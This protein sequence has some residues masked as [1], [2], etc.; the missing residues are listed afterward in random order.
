MKRLIL[1][2]AVF[3]LAAGIEEAN[4][5]PCKNGTTRCENGRSEVC[6]GGRWRRKG[7]CETKK[8][9]ASEKAECKQGETR[10]EA[11]RKRLQ[12]CRKGQWR[13]S[14]RRCLPTACKTKDAKQC[15]G[16]QLY[17]C[18]LTHWAATGVRCQAVAC[19]T[20][21]A[22]KCYSRKVYQCAGPYWTATNTS[23]VPCKANSKRCHDRTIEHCGSNALW[24]KTSP[25][26]RCTPCK[27][28]RC[29]NQRVQECKYG[30]YHRTSLKCGGSC[31]KKGK[32]CMRKKVARK[33]IYYGE[34]KICTGA[35]WTYPNKRCPICKRGS[36]VC[37][38][39]G[40]TSYGRLYACKVGRL[41]VS[42]LCNFCNSTK[43][44]LYTC[45]GTNA[46][47][48]KTGTLY[49]HKCAGG[50]WQNQRKRC[51]P[52][53]CSHQSQTRCAN[54]TIQTCWQKA[55]WL[56]TKTACIACKQGEQRKCIN[57]YRHKCRFGYW[58][59]TRFTCK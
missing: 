27:A 2:V 7:R 43:G 33:N 31:T 23:C 17:Q 46:R 13:K 50:Y 18:Q 11:R 34:L 41:L 9:Q 22:K 19:K 29:L 35:F 38:R 47:F 1:F 4:A 30:Y 12:T 28:A 15:S 6:E 49:A 3:I 8:K 56:T 32:V 42:G 21:G 39:V 55:V 25:A 53:K 45:M 57:R 58:N 20:K 24:S 54:G 36:K 59:K 40:G 52:G 48:P 14:G 5:A 51:A 44:P 10:C 16:A 37:Q 26:Q